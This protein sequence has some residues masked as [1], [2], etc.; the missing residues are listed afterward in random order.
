MNFSELN[1]LNLLTPNGRAVLASQCLAQTSGGGGRGLVNNIFVIL[2]VE[3]IRLVGVL[4][5][6]VG[7]LV[8]NGHVVFVQE[9]GDGASHL[10]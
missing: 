3:Q 9:L 8:R 6:W 10:R 5:A 7:K 2:E 4:C 1:G